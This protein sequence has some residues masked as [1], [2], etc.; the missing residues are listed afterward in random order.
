M[1]KLNQILAV[2]KNTKSRAH[3]RT[4]ESYQLLQKADLMAG[5]ERTYQ[6]KEDGGEVFPSESKR[7]QVRAPEVLRDVRKA[8]VGLFDVVGT[9]EWANTH[10]RADVV[11]EGT[12]LAKSVPVTYLLFLEKQ[13]TDLHT[14]VKSLPTHDPAETWSYD[15]TTSL[16]KTPVVKTTK[17][18]K[19]PRVVEK[20]PATE[21]HPAQVEIFHEDVV[22]GHWS[23]VKLSGAM[24]AD[25]VKDLLERIEAVQRAVKFA[26]EEANSSVADEQKGLGERILG[27]VFKA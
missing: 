1:A 27:Y 10:A 24:P 21:K 13:L 6:P 20:A 26:R 17:T 2:V 5:L 11:V 16:W 8:L 22:V 12:T 15:E 4:T 18:A 19:R 23:N 14:L 9:Q 3:Q 25:A 7:V